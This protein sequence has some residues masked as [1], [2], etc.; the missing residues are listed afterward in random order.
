[1]SLLFAILWTLFGIV[2]DCKKRP[3]TLNTICVVTTSDETTI[4]S[5]Y[6]FS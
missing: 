4:N 1:M 5:F 3:E 6:L 2:D